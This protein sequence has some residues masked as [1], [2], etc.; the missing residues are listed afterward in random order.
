MCVRE[1]TVQNVKQLDFETATWASEWKS[2]LDVLKSGDVEAIT[3]EV[4]PESL[5]ATDEQGYT[6]LHRAAAA[7][8]GDVITGVHG[9]GV[10]RVFIGGKAVHMSHNHRPTL[11]LIEAG[12]SVKAANHFGLTPLCEAERHKNTSAYKAIKDAG[13]RLASS[14]H[15]SFYPLHAAVLENDLEKAQE[16]VKGGLEVSNIS[17][18]LNTPL[19][20]AAAL[21]REALANFLIKNG[22]D[23]NFPNRYA[24]RVRSACSLLSQIFF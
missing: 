4:K 22:A 5:A 12:A 20:L 6:L 23:V 19:H 10:G 8:N 14:I 2:L 7:C 21:G 13:G 9:G 24:V 1:W 15:T 3:A 18:D 16:L 11:A 17:F